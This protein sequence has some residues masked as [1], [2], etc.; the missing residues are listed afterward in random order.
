M[1]AQDK[2]AGRAKARRQ[3]RADVYDLVGT[4]EAADILNVERPR[5]GRW[6]R[7]GTM[8]EPVVILAATPVWHRDDIE[9]MRPWVDE[10]RRSRAGESIAA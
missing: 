6:M 5:I 10:H 7:A 2:R 3:R 9:A 1:S 8:P 4:A